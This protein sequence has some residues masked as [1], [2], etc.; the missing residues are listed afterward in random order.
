MAELRRDNGSM[1]SIRQIRD[2]KILLPFEEELCQQL[3]LS[4]EEYFKFL[5]YT[6]SK[7]G[8]R[9]REYD[10]IPYVVNFEALG[11][12][13]AGGGLTAL[14][15]IVVGVALNLI[16]YFLTP[17][18]K[19]PK[20]PPRL[21]TPG[22]EGV[23]R[24]APQTG[25]D[26]IQEL[27]ELGAVIPLV[28][29]KYERVNGVDYGGVRVNT[30]LIWS[31]MRSLS[32]GQQIKAIFNLSSG[33]LAT[34]PDFNG[35]A[36]GD[37]LLK[38][39][40][41]SKFR[42]FF[43]TGDPDD[44]G[45]FKNGVHQYPLGIL[46]KEKDRNGNTSSDDVALP[47]V[48]S[49]R[50]GSFESNTFCATRTPSTQNV[51]GN[52]NP[53]PNSMRFML[54]YE[55]ILLQENLDDDTG[56]DGEISIKQKTILKRRKIETDFPRYQAVIAKNGS[57]TEEDDNVRKNDLITFQISD[58]DPNKEFEDKF[59]D[60]GTE[61]VASSVNADRENTD[62][63]LAIGEQYLIG[64]AIGSLISS[65]I[66]NSGEDSIWQKNLTKQFT[67]KIDEPG[68]ISIRKVTRAHSPF[69][70]FLIQKI[71]IGVITNS[72]KC[73]TTEIGLKS[74]VNRQITGFANVNSHPGYW[75]YYGEP[76]NAGEEAENGVVHDY[77]KKNGNIS[78]GQMSK[79]VKRYSF[80]EL[81][82][83]AVGDDEW[84]KIGDKPFAVLGRTPQPQ[85]N[86][87]RINHTD[88]ELREF[89]LQPVAGNFMKREYIGKEINLLTGTKLDHIQV[90]SAGIKSIY[91]NGQRDYRL[92]DNRASNPEWFLGKIPQAEDAGEGKVLAFN[93]TFVGT[94]NTKEDYIPFE[95]RYDG[96][97]ENRHFVYQR[98][99][100]FAF[101][102]KRRTVLEFY[103]DD[104]LKGKYTFPDKRTGN[105]AANN[106]EFNFVD[107][108]IRYSTG[109][110]IDGFDGRY[111]IVRSRLG[112]VT[113]GLVSGYEDKTVNPSG[114]HGSGLEVK[115]QLFDNG[116][117]RWEITN[118]GS[119]Y[120]EADSVTIQFPQVTVNGNVVGGDEQ[121]FCLVEFGDYVTEPWPEGQNLNPFD[122]IADY[123]KFD[124]ER[125]SHLDQPE[126]QIT[127]VNE[128]IRGSNEDDNFLPYSQLS[129]VGIKMNSSKEFTNFSQLSVYVKNG[130]KVEN[131]I[132]NTRES[133][134]LF[135]NIAYHLL[136]DSVNGAGNL[137]GETQINKQEM[138]KAAEFCEANKLYWDGVITQQ[139]NIR[140]FIYQ[141]ATFCLLDFT[142]KGGQFS[143][144]P[145]VPVT[146]N[147]EIN[148]EVLAKD[149]VKALFTDGNTRSL[150]VSFLSPEERQLFQARVLYRNE[151][152]N[153]F[154]KTQVLDLRLGDNLGGSESD[155]REVFDMSNF[156]TSEKH[157]RTFAEYAL[158][159]RKFVD[160]GISF[161]TTPESAMSLEPGDY[162]RFFSEITHNDRFENGYI[163]A[164][165]TIQSQ[166]NT[167]PIGANIFY[168]R[169]FNENGSDFGEPREAVLTADNNKASSQFR[170]SVFTIQK[171]DTADRIYKIE[172]ITYT[173]EGFVQLTATHQPLD[174]DGKFK[175][176]K[177]NQNIFSDED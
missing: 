73:T 145:T 124:A 133:S 83:R 128:M 34:R 150:K 52:Y 64:T 70:L 21:T 35:Y 28:F 80:F 46:P 54:P 63:S 62:D 132:N 56:D 98:T 108:D 86:F 123:L 144:T 167:N 38:N 58:H 110:A 78:L 143:L 106:T 174:A 55:L 12:V 24:F 36:I 114:G 79:Y 60:W 49:D 43:Y 90:N 177:Y 149:L 147:H 164:D 89:K 3:G 4:K 7:N 169:A 141:N 116:A 44:D 122:A 82:A 84:T 59:S 109:N 175:V 31:Q 68:R 146:S 51:F 107:G 160:H 119:G 139:Q 29:A 166:G 151:V 69:E 97:S 154:A 2:R 19:P 13:K 48:D 92:T 96:D 67:F 87:I 10:N 159:V 153:G 126:H 17:K 100:T 162:I 40:P 165:G 152:E 42:L 129:N 95:T 41:A 75:Q 131:L 105:F 137:I 172:S 140:E 37:V 99:E 72:F 74:V 81:Y 30:Q 25:F 127:Y 32:K 20:T 135:P 120:K 173:E 112:N 115:V 158:V 111:E 6:L 170:N 71:A 121:V 23:R 16:S 148:R 1:E 155:P 15:Q 168:W 103:Y 66:G 8:K 47:L 57:Q 117:K 77:E 39:Y 104:E 113:E 161:E 176:L 26:S 118:S 22:Q 65:N 85:Y 156:C 134:N 76:D 101:R 102:P 18:P 125:P 9:P 93:R 163:S 88:D 11:L 45:K 94:P 142:I 61:D 91:F 50:S 136:T 171:T 53:V 5:E 33:E 138:E 14:G 157:A 130:I 27:A